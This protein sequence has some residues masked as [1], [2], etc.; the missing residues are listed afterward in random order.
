MN[1][2]Q[3]ILLAGRVAASYV[4]RF[5]YLKVDNFPPHDWVI[6]AIMTA[7]NQR[8]GLPMSSKGNVL[9]EVIVIDY[10][11]HRGERTDRW[12]SP[13]SLDH[14]ETE[15]HPGLQWI[16]TGRDLQKHATRSFAMSGIH[17][18]RVPNES[19]RAK[20]LESSNTKG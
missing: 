1:R 9:T 6:D 19:D 16:L 4:E 8:P 2:E 12:V 14:K 10:T 15:W 18:W 20:M 3:A 7:G 5:P 13:M 17:E 11:N